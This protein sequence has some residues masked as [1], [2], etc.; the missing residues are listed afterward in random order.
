MDHSRII[1]DLDLGERAHRFRSKPPRDIPTAVSTLPTHTLVL[2]DPRHH[3]LDHLGKEM[4]HVLPPQLHPHAAGRPLVQAEIGNGV[5]GAENGR[6]DIGNGLDDHAR[7]VQ[8]RGLGAGASEER[9]HVD[10]VEPRDVSKGDGAAE[11][12]ERGASSWCS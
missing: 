10:L 4:I 8:V 3:H 5:L 6:A 1:I 9:V 11:E 7:D 12:R 2:L